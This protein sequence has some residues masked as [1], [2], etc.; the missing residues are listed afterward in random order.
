MA[1][2]RDQAPV[3]SVHR[4]RPA[5]L[6]AAVLAIVCLLGPLLLQGCET[7]GRGA[8]APSDTQTNRVF[9]EV[10]VE[11][12]VLSRDQVAEAMEAVEVAAGV[13]LRV[14]LAKAA[15]D[16]GMLTSA[17]V[18]D[19][20]REMR[21]RG[22]FPPIE[23]FELLS[24]LGRGSMGVVYKARQAPTGRVVALKVLPE[25]LK[26][27]EFFIG[28][29]VREGEIAAKIVHPNV[30]RVLE[31]GKSRGRH[32][33]AMELIDGPDVERVLE[34]GPL[35]ED[36]AL[37]IALGVAKGLQ[38][39][40]AKGIVHRDVKPANIMLTRAGVPKL[41]DFGIAWPS[42]ESGRRMTRLGGLAAGTPRYM[43]PEQCRGQKDVD[44]RA[45]TY[46]LGIALFQMV[47]GRCPFTG[48]TD[49]ATIRKQIEEPLPDPR[50]LNP[51]LSDP[52]VALIRRMTAKD[53]DK[54]YR[55][56]AAMIEAIKAAR[57]KAP[58]K[59]G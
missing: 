32:Y 36:R 21:E 13:G 7:S 59:A 6:R 14:D 28:R 38:A 2:Q 39:A 44:G 8:T 5:A 30:V 11:T 46:G 58:R 57:K 53:R 1:Q 50:A 23:G 15:W 37:G 9:A 34:A 54:R 42:A 25:T 18:A 29:F 45:D 12:G 33:I 22:V 31:V 27:D 43:S 16:R 48:D 41:C 10:A 17:Q 52:V 40:H 20:K 3:A 49:L 55:D 19:V 4:G 35:S 47:C 26:E 56:D 51:K 24:V